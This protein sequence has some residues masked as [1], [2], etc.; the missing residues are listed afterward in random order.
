M[1]IWKTIFSKLKNI[2]FK[3]KIESKK[4]F[5]SLEKI[6]LFISIGS[7]AFF[8]VVFMTILPGIAQ[9]KEL[10][11]D[12]SDLIIKIYGN[13]TI[14]G[15]K[16][17]LKHKKKELNNKEK[18]FLNNK[19]AEL[20]LLNQ[21]LPQDDDIYK[22]AVFLEDYTVTL[23]TIE[24]PI[25]ITNISF[26][27]F[28]E[29]S[30]PASD[31]KQKSLIYIESLQLEELFGKDRNLW[32]QEIFTDTQG[33]LILFDP[34]LKEG[35]F[36]KI[37]DIK[38]RKTLKKFWESYPK[39]SIPANYR[40]VSLSLSVEAHKERFDQFLEFINNSGNTENYYFKGNPVPI[41]SVNSVKLPMG[42][43]NNFHIQK[44]SL[45]IDVYF[46]EKE[47]LEKL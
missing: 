7:I 41:M 10:K 16:F 27:N 46:Q 39:V 34:Y 44:Y 1:D 23:T 29:I 28:K 31:L 32:P 38:K 11:L 43:K 24:K 2:K 36:L 30:I 21:S 17:I 19:E 37:S 8:V 35:D 14:E 33:D 12:L 13:T 6:I 26:G 4:F 5:S 9:M 40:V 45:K 3:K 22:I 15:K 25:A 42:E 47:V 20:S 18:A